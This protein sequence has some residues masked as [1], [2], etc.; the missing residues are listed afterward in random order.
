MKNYLLFFL[1]SIFTLNVNAQITDGSVAPDFTTTD[2]E[3]NTHSLSSYLNAGKTVILNISATWCGPCWN[4]KQTGA[5]SD[6]YYSYGSNGSD[7]VVLL[8]VEGDPATGLAELNG[9]GDTVGDW[10]S[11]TPFPIID[12][13]QIANDYQISYFPTV[14]RICP[15]G[16][17]YEM[18]QLPNSGIINDIN[19][20]CSGTLQGVNNHAKLEVDEVSLCDD[21]VTADFNVSLKNLGNNPINSFGLDVISGS[22]STNVTETASLNSI[23]EEQSF[24]INA[25]LDSNLSNSL[26]LVSVNGSSPYTSNLNFVDLQVS[27]AGQTDDTDIEVHVYTDNY[28]GE[29]SWELKDNQGNL[30][31]S[32]GPY[33]PGNDDQFG[34]GGPDALTTKIHDVSLPDSEQCFNLE[35]LDSYGDGWSLTDGSITPG[36]EIFSNGNSFYSTGS[37]GNFGN[38]KSYSNAFKYTETFSNDTFEQY[39]FDMYPNPTYG[40]VNVSAEQPFVMEIYDLKGKNVFQQEIDNS[41]QLDLSSL[42]AGVY[43]TKVTI[44]SSSKTTKLIIK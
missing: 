26:D 17:V 40:Q 39:G 8:Y 5:L 33:Q 2:I 44:G 12:D 29:I 15:D 23:F 22:N 20:N 6:I 32:G 11:S 9:S 19:T 14:Y 13:A 36:V 30:V 38:S 4:Y 3:G 37:V 25:L 16:F 28:P 7:E 35:I 21:G 1:L 41:R 42:S 24:T 10:V 31:A 27:A 18:G 43:L 34:G